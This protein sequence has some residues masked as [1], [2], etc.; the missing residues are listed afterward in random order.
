VKYA[1]WFVYL[2][3]EP[4]SEVCFIQNG[5]SLKQIVPVYKCGLRHPFISFLAEVLL[6]DEPTTGLD[7]FTAHRLVAQLGEL[8]KKKNKII[9]MTIHQPRSVIFKLLDNV[10]MLSTGEVVYSGPAQQLV[11]YFTNLGHICP[12]YA[13]PLD[14][15][16]KFTFL[17]FSYCE[18]SLVFLLHSYCGVHGFG[19]GVKMSG[20]LFDVYMSRTFTTHILYSYP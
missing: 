12:T 6:L 5:I 4:A 15:Y 18:F 8:A 13:N 20:L 17:R 7:S 11:P 9:A 2:F 10:C 14:T 1:V 16:C 19:P 3:L